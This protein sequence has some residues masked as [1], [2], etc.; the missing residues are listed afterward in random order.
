MYRHQRQS[1]AGGD[2]RAQTSGRATQGRCHRKAGQAD[3]QGALSANRVR[4]P[5]TEQQQSAKRQRVGGDDPL[6]LGVGKG[7]LTLRGWESDVHHRRVEASISCTRAMN[8]RAV[9]RCGVHGGLPGPTNGRA[10][11]G[12][13]AP[14]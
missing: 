12:S 11:H 6:P 9:Q 7:E 8:P 14:S 13:C 4:D 5:P 2:E 10:E 1:S 3:Q